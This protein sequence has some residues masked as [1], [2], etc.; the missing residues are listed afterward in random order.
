MRMA[1]TSN[2]SPA[3]RSGEKRAIAM[4]VWD[5]E[6]G[7]RDGQKVVSSWMELTLE[8]EPSSEAR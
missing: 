1:L 3:L 2:A 5:G 6:A 8:G 4:A 7:D